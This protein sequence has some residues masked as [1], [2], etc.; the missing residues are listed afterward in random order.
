[1]PEVAPDSVAVVLFTSGTTGTPKPV[2]LSHRNIMSN[3]RALQAER[4]VGARDRALLP[5]PLHH[6]YALTVGL[7]TP[8]AVGAAVIFPAGVSG[9]EIAEALRSGGATV[10]V[11]VPRLYTALLDAVRSRIARAPAPLRL[12]AAVSGAVCRPLRRIGLDLAP[13]LFR[14][15]R[16]QVGPKL[17][18]LVSGGAALDAAV[19]R[20]L[21][22][23]GWEVLTGYGLTETSPILT[24]MRR[25]AARPGT[26]GKA[27]PGVSLRI[28]AP[29]ADGIGEIQA[30][31]ASVFTGYLGDAEATWAAFTPDG[32]FRTG[33]IGFIDGGDDLHVVGRV[34]ETIVLPGEKKLV[35]EDVERAF[36]GASEIREIAVLMEAGR[37]VA[38]VVPQPAGD[39]ATERARV[40]EALVRAARPLPSYAHPSGFELTSGPLPR[41][42]IGK[43]RRHLLPEL[44]VQ[45]R[46]SRRPMKPGKPSAADERLLADPAVAQVRHWLERRYPGRTLDLDASPQL[47]LGIDSPRLARPDARSAART[48]GDPHPGATGSG[49]K[50]A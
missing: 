41:T 50:P 45:A 43:L 14:R 25:G 13:W 21:A 22:A 3:I 7:L 16:L 46:A 5:L 39:A 4:L 9:P 30:R 38:L 31:G 35:P 1:M 49:D 44:Y 2:P 15:V 18:L 17:R 23:F 48:R 42:P 24:F 26:V 28:V 12:L 37:L 20:G 29:D 36:A 11:G 33:D 19:E 8:L 10:L 6:V 34:T 40:R 47:D 32:W 27:L